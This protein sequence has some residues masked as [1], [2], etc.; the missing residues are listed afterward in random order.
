MAS[1]NLLAEPW[2]TAFAFGAAAAAVILVFW[3]QWVWLLLFLGLLLGVLLDAIADFGVRRAKLP[4]GVAVILAAVVFL[5]GLGGTLV[6]IATPL[7]RQGTDLIHS[8]PETTARFSRT[9]ERYRHDYPLLD[10]LFPAGQ[11]AEKKPGPEPAQM[12]KKALLTASTALDW[13]ARLL[14]TFFFGLFLAWDPER[15]IRGVAELW[16]RELV[17]AR[18]ALFRA[19]GAALRTYLFTVGVTMLVM[20]GLWT[21]GLWVIGIKFALLFGAIGG[22]V[23]IV[24]YVGPLLGLVPPLLYALATDGTKTIYVLLLYTVLHI[25]EGYILVP[26]VLHE[27]ER[28]PPPLVVASI[29]LSGTLFG[30]LGVLLAVPLGTT[31]Y[32]CLQEIVYKPRGLTGRQE[33]R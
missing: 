33:D 27:R 4:H 26:Y 16:P 32:V 31:V 23:E 14:G 20:A 1:R 13:L 2:K 22:L 25:V 7:L 28:F 21:L 9:L 18:I 12:A 17:P 6:L 29:L 11:P 19:I 10:R 8:L 3:A 24:P 30:V 15:W 5:L